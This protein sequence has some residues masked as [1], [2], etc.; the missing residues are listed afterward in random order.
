MWT[1]LQLEEEEVVLRGAVGSGNILILSVSVRGSDRT[2]KTCTR[3]LESFYRRPPSLHDLHGQSEPAPQVWSVESPADDSQLRSRRCCTQPGLTFDRPSQHSQANRE[4]QCLW[5]G[6]QA[7][8]LF[9]VSLPRQIALDE[10]WFTLRVQHLRRQDS[11]TLKPIQINPA[12]LALLHS[13][14]CTPPIVLYSAW[15]DIISCQSLITDLL[16]WVFWNEYSWG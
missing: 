1:A 9:E 13:K 15:L 16:L 11:T 12:L 14:R 4:A 10:T 3:W 8:A 7:H 6:I 5:G 2:A